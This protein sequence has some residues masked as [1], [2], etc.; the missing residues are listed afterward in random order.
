MH[1][2]RILPLIFVLFASAPAC[3]ARL[4]VG[5][6]P[7]A[8]EESP[9]PTPAPTSTGSLGDPT[10]PTKLA[11]APCAD[12][13][14]CWSNPQPT[15]DDFVSAWAD[16]AGEVWAATI[17]GTIV[18][19]TATS[20]ETV[21]QAKN[22]VTG[23]HV[24][25]GKS[26][27]DTHVWAFVNHGTGGVSTSTCENQHWVNG[28]L[29]PSPQQVCTNGGLH[30]V[31]ELSAVENVV[32]A[33]GPIANPDAKTVLVRPS[34][35]IIFT[36]Q[37]TGP[38]PVGQAFGQIP[39]E[40][41]DTYIDAFA[42]AD[43]DGTQVW[44]L[45]DTGR[46]VTG[47]KTSSASY[48]PSE[49][50]FADRP[51]SD[52]FGVG[53]WGTS[54]TNVTVV[55]EEVDDN[56]WRTVF[57]HFDGTAWTTTQSLPGCVNRTQ[58]TK[59]VRT[60]VRGGRRVRGHGSKIFAAAG[61]GHCAG[62]APLYEG[63]LDGTGFHVST[64]IDPLVN[65]FAHAPPY[66]AEG[67]NALFAVGIHGQ[68]HGLGT[69]W[70]KLA[71][72]NPTDRIAAISVGAHDSVWAVRQNGERDDGS[73]APTPATLL[74][75]DG[76]T[77]SDALALTTPDAIEY[78]L[79]ASSSDVWVATTKTHDIAGTS[80]LAHW[81]GA[82]WST[83][84][85]DGSITGLVASAKDD[86]WLA[87]N[88]TARSGLLH[89]DG[90]TWSPAASDLDVFK[91]ASTRAHDLWVVGYA[92]TGKYSPA[93]L[94]R[95]DGHTFSAL[96]DCVSMVGNFQGGVESAGPL[97]LVPAGNEVWSSDG[98]IHW[99]GKTCTQTTTAK[100]DD[101][102]AAWASSAGDVWFGGGALFSGRA[103]IVRWDGAALST[104]QERPFGQE[105]TAFGGLGAGDA[106]VGT[107]GGGLLRTSSPKDPGTPT[108]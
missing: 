60:S 32:M 42:A 59:G 13:R 8:A 98:R 65:P 94:F 92:T 26:G 64:S 76:K 19:K 97:Q 66:F 57:R 83:S 41:G 106:W 45:S 35:S 52:V 55:I 53:V 104:D 68:M 105:I 54:R 24:L 69:T 22:D 75:F 25:G 63:N 70:T 95:G 93:L 34:G 28:V 51:T 62:P 86:A 29:D 89:W 10:A 7:P 88:A 107:L 56:Q 101:G 9:T 48:I 47:T 61:G 23:V 27:N 4:V 79:A 78:N 84:T 102:F 103:S 12:G 82:A 90:T 87:V 71:G 100:V 38:A 50:V 58:D 80:E 14:L 91:L 5:D 21:Y 67:G 73:P 6:A 44:L 39:L 17:N 46:L 40:T 30:F 20:Y 11:Y 15:G 16:D 2:A 33:P 43:A 31:G 37:L 3:A 77:W 1:A 18:R 72:D 74:H 36:A 81:D 85:I 99:D 96:S 49:I 108:N